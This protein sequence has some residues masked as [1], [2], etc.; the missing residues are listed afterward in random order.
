VTLAS[1]TRNARTR[2]VCALC[3]VLIEIGNPIGK[4]PRRGWAHIACII[5]A[6]QAAPS[7]PEVAP[8]SYPADT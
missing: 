3:P 4:L 8:Y 7:Q 2:S 1:R 5:A 6:Q